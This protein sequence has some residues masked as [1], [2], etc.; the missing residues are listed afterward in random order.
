MMTDL[1]DLDTV[2]VP[3]SVCV[4]VCGRSSPVA[5]SLRLYGVTPTRSAPNHLQ[6][7]SFLP[8]LQLSGTWSPRQVYP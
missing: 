1:A 2:C 6:P 3:I 5:S 7:L 8:S 4:Q